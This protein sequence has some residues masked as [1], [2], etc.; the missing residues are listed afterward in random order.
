MPTTLVVYAVLAVLYGLIWHN[1]P[2]RERGSENY[3]NS[4]KNQK[5]TVWK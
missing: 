5:E 2:A 3:A 1:Q 4:A